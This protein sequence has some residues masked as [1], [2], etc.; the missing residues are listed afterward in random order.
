MSS[1]PTAVDPVNPILRTVSL[2]IMD[3]PGGRGVAGGGRGVAGGEQDQRQN[4]VTCF[5]EIEF[6]VPSLQ[7]P[8]PQQIHYLSN[9]W[10]LHL[11]LQCP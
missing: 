10:P 1:F 2:L 8:T 4:T 7:L 3:W 6:M 5:T 9:L 11:V